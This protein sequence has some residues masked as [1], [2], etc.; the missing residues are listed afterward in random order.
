MISKVITQEVSERECRWQHYKKQCFS[1]TH[2]EEGKGLETG[3]ITIVANNSQ[4]LGGER[5][6]ADE[7]ALE[8]LVK[9]AP[10]RTGRSSQ[11]FNSYVRTVSLSNVFEWFGLKLKHCFQILS[12]TLHF[13]YCNSNQNQILIIAFLWC[14]IST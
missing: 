6:T 3:S 5:G 13:A 9:R 12:I 2:T 4:V 11:H 10:N 7:W 8:T 14:E 1:R